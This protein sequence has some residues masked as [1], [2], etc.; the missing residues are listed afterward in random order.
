MQ[1]IW[2]LKKFFL[3]IGEISEIYIKAIE[4]EIKDNFENIETATV[5]FSEDLENIEKIEIILKNNSNN[6]DEIKNFLKENY[7]VTDNV[8]SIIS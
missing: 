1:P 8:I 6:T 7:K 4:S 2:R 3:P 5:I